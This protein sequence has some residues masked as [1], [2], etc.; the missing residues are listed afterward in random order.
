MKWKRI[1]ILND[2]VL[3]YAQLYEY[4]LGFAGIKKNI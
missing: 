3:I 1:D 4:W 2:S